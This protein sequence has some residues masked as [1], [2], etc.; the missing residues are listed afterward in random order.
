MKTVVGQKENGFCASLSVC[1]E[2]GREIEI[3][4]EKED[5]V[6]ITV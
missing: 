5:S 3:E 1:E 6:T 4:M 2:R